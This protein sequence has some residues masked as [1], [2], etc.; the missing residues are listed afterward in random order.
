MAPNRM[1]AQAADKPEQQSPIEDYALIGNCRSAA[2]VSRSGSIDWLCWP[3]FDSAACF[4]AILG[5][6][7]NGRWRIRPADP[8][9]VVR[10]HYWPG[11]MILETVFSTGRGEVALIDFMT[12]EGQSL[13]RI[14][15]G[16]QGSVEMTFDLALRF[17]YGSAVPWVTRLNHGLRA[18]A[19]PD[20]VVL[21][22]EVPLHGRAMTTVARFSVEAGKRTRFVLTY[23]ESH[24]PPPPSPPVYGAVGRT[25]APMKV[26]IGRW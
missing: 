21:H 17:E 25:A 1:Q 5:T 26:P 11:T 6:P 15:E 8:N 2:L 13:A 7:A 18:V 4:A 22:A 14:V 9:A 19:G 12:V 24:L 16:R 23:A 20:Q 3:R 10:R